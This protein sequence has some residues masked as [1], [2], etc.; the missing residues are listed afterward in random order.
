[1]RGE[2]HPCGHS[3]VEHR[4][5]PERVVRQKECRACIVKNGQRIFA[6]HP[7]L[8]GVAPPAIGERKQLALRAAANLGAAASRLAQNV[9]PVRDETAPQQAVLIET[10]GWRTA[11][12][13]RVLHPPGKSHHAGI[14]AIT[15]YLSWFAG[16]S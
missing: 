3:S 15:V 16:S 13:L 5:K 7:G 14:L 2:Y 11:C 8:Q 10:F 12:E 6:E 9:L 1:M 4:H